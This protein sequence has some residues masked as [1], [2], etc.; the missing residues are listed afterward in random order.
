MEGGRPGTGGVAE[1]KALLDDALG[2]P[3]AGGDV[4]DGGAGRG[5]RAEGLHLVGRVHGDADHVLGKRQLAVG[6][7][8]LDDAAGHGMVGGDGALAGE[9]VE[10][11]RGGGRR[12]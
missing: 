2:D 9:V 1:T 7:A 4:G 5:E 3:E 6:D 10:R 12:R 11:G 8:V